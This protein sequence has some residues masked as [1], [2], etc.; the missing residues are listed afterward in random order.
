MN[1][2][3]ELPLEAKQLNDLVE[4]AKDFLLMNGIC[5]R[6]KSAYDRDALHLAP[7]LLFPSAFPEKEFRLGVDLQP[8]LNE[9]MHRVAH[10]H[11]FLAETLKKTIEV[12]DFTNRLY[13]IYETVRQEGFRQV[14]QAVVL[15]RSSTRF[16]QLF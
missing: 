14:R 11:D 6:Q 5:M 16:H 12:D 7:F 13:Q 1:S 2:A 3:V 9:L 8:V 10:D 4:K 15:V